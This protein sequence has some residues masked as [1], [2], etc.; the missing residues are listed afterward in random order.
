MLFLKSS[1]SLMLR[2]EQS[3]PKIIDHAEMRHQILSESH[4][5]FGKLGYQSVSMRTLAG[6]IGVTTGVLYH[7]FKSKEELVQAVL[8]MGLEHS[9]I[10]KNSD[11]TF[12]KISGDLSLVEK[13]TVLFEN[14][15]NK[16]DMA[17][18]NIMLLSDYFRDLKTEDEVKK[19][20]KVAY[21]FLESFRKSMSLE[22]QEIDLARFLLTYLVG[23]H[24]IR[25]WTAKRMSIQEF[26]ENFLK[27]FRPSSEKREPH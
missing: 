19:N 4:K 8:S 16:D 24:T 5:I 2:G 23:M 10:G 22:P 26:G 20:Y 15:S 1:L 25:M 13:I 9:I 27:F 7:Y 11:H 21:Q 18:T 17:I 12:S 14:M 3:L 6:Q